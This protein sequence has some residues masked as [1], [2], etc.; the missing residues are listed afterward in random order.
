M[1]KIKEES[2]MRNMVMPKMKRRLFASGKRNMPPSLGARLAGDAGK[3]EE[4]QAMIELH[5]SKESVDDEKEVAS[6]WRH[7][8]LI[9]YSSGGQQLDFQYSEDAGQEQWTGEL[10]VE[11]LG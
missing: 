8:Y 2:E 3:G 11:S 5:G 1:A 4:E 10:S 9:D 6:R 7:V